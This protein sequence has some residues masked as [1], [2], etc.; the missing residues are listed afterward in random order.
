L[1][2][3]VL[4]L[5][6]PL[7]VQA[8]TDPF[9]ILCSSDIGDFLICYPKQEAQQLFGILDVA[10]VGPLAVHTR[11]SLPASNLKK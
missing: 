6:P 9:S 4:I 5:F 3:P 11:K 1:E 10:K 7:R 2:L 8:T